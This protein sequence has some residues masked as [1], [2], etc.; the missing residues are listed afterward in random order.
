MLSLANTLPCEQLIP[1]VLGWLGGLE[2]YARP[3]RPADIYPSPA[4]RAAVV[5]EYAVQA[6]PTHRRPISAI[7][8]SWE[9]YVVATSD[10]PQ[11]ER[12]ALSKVRRRSW[13]YTFSLV[14]A[15]VEEMRRR[16]PPPDR[17]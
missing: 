5:A 15:A 7:R 2:P 12:I 16:L 8:N 6:S 10:L 14:C 9:F 4:G 17:S 3:V 11:T 13:A 1:E